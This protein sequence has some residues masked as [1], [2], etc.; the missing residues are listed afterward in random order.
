MVASYSVNDQSDAFLEACAYARA[1]GV[2]GEPLHISALCDLYRFPP[3]RVLLAGIASSGNMVFQNILVELLKSARP[4]GLLRRLNPWRAPQTVLDHP[5]AHRFASVSLHHLDSIRRLVGRAFG[6]GM[7]SV[8]GSPTHC[9]VGQCL[10]R[11]PDFYAAVGGLPLR[12]HAWAGEWSASHEP[13]TADCIAF[14]RR[15]GYRIVYILRHP[16]DVIVS[17][18]AKVAGAVPG[19][20]DAGPVLSDAEWFGAALDTVARY[21][22]EILNHRQA[23]HFVRYENLMAEPVREIGRLA[24]HLESHVTD[25]DARRI[26]RLF[27][28]VAVAGAQHFWQPGEGKWRTHLGRGHRDAVMSS[29]LVKTAAAMGYGIDPADFGGR[30]ETRPAD[31]SRFPRLVWVDAILE[32]PIGKPL[33]MRGDLVRVE[34]RPL[35]ITGYFCGA[36]ERAG[37]EL[38]ASEEL[39]LLVRAARTSMDRP[40]SVAGLIRPS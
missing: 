8:I 33:T 14:Y 6:V 40:T 16:L 19:E 31:G 35:G 17:L 36:A 9:D 25:E 30:D 15:N 34:N 24:R 28:G 4:R 23:L 5:A 27:D 37:R 12:H 26:W 22:V 7:H 39:A 29:E 1:N 21:Y 10:V 20:K 18:A 32:I 2:A 3:R 38:L 11:G 13:P